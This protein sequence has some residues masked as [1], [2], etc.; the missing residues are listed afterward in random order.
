M[1]TPK[2]QVYTKNGTPSGS[3]TTPAT[4][5]DNAA[6]RWDGTTGAALQD[7]ALIISDLGV[8]SGVTANANII[9]TGTLTTTL[10][11]NTPV[12]TTTPAAGYFSALREKIGGF[13][14]IFTHANSADRTYT[15]PN[16][17][18]TLATLAGTETLT[19]KTLTSPTIGSFINANHTHQSAGEGSTLLPGALSIPYVRVEDQK[20]KNTHAGASTSTTWHT[21]VLNTEVQDTNSKA[22]VATNQVTLQAGTWDIRISA[23]GYASSVQ[24]I[25]LRNDTDSTIPF[26]GWN[27][28]ASSTDT[29]VTR[30]WASGRVTIASAKAFSI[31]HYTAVG[32]ASFGLGVA[33]NVNDPDAAA[34]LEVYA[35]FEA[36]QVG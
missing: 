23:P 8:I 34:R 16:F 25:V 7:S 9:N 17:D 29:S 24:A 12:G 22:S 27:E 14:G 4:S 18:G 33:L 5:T 28:D 21:R 19:N 2:I 30:C 31:R 35:V 32:V 13:F 3:I 20:A 26:Y 15:L 10:I 1:S 6:V 11:D 36:W